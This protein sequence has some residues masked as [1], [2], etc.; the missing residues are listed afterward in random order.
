[1]QTSDI[2]RFAVREYTIKNL[3]LRP[4]H[5]YAPPGV[6]DEIENE[7]LDRLSLQGVP[8]STLRDADVVSVHGVDIHELPPGQFGCFC[9]AEPL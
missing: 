7:C 2:V 4:G 3:G 1:M 9:T 8:Y 6:I 5:F